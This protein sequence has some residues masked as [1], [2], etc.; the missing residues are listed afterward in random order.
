MNVAAEVV[1]KSTFQRLLPVFL[2]RHRKHQVRIKCS[3]QLVAEQIS[4]SHRM[5]DGRVLIIFTL[6]TALRK[7]M[8]EETQGMLIGVTL[9]API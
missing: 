4:V 2:G 9:P 1:K 3:Y 5:W 6:T 7:S 8:E